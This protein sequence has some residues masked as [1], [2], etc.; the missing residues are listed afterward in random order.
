MSAGP[1][2]P[3]SQ[4]PRPSPGRPAAATRGFSPLHKPTLKAELAPG[5]A[6]ARGVSGLQGP[7]LSH[8]V[9][10]QLC[11]LEMQSQ[12]SLRKPDPFLGN[13]AQFSLY[14]GVLCSCGSV[15]TPSDGREALEGKIPLCSF[16]RFISSTS[17]D[18]W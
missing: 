7:H 5:C 8:Q 14:V 18:T 3:V 9:S 17:P 6:A 16:H 10:A 11:S 2:A 4:R 12:Q 1:A 15:L 13:T